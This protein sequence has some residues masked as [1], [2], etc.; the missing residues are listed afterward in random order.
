MRCFSRTWP[1]HV[2]IHGSSAIPPSTMM[3]GAMLDDPIY[4]ELRSHPR[5]MQLVEVRDESQRAASASY[6][7]R[8]RLS[9]RNLTIPHAAP[10]W[11]PL[12]RRGKM[13]AAQQIR[14][15]AEST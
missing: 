9:L 10:R 11:D 8:T 13:A 7:S 3:G 12:A 1:H 15:P 6:D 2:S 5:L 4:E 14:M